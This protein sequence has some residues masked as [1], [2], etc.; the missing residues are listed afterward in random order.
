VAEGVAKAV[1][2]E[3][4]ALVDLVRSSKKA[5]TGAAPPEASA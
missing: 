5:A 4:D 2:K 3:S 1:P